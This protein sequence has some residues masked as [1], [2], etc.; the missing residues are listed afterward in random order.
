MADPRVWGWDAWKTMH[1][2]SLCYPLINPSRAKRKAARD[3]Y[4]SLQ[5]LL[6]CVSCRAHYAKHFKATFNANTTASRENL[7]R[8]VYDC[9]NAVNRRLGK[10][11]GGV[12]LT[13]LPTIYNAFPLNY[14]SADGKSLLREPR[15]SS[16][17]GGGKNDISDDLKRAIQLHDQLANS[18]SGLTD[19]DS[20]SAIEEDGGDSTAL[21][22]LV[23]VSIVVL[24]IIAVVA[25]V[26]GNYIRNLQKR[27]QPENIL[28]QR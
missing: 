23:V 3:F 21:V 27:R 16:P 7:V 13:D 25:F 18:S 14:V 8:W 20:T 5:H 24:A 6:P 10:T 15:S 9:H 22:V 17:L 4:S 12:K 19:G 1:R 11:N 2:F 28:L 26:V